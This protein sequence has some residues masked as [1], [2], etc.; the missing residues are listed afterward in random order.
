MLNI[1]KLQVLLWVSYLLLNLYDSCKQSNICAGQYW[2]SQSSIHF[3]I[4]LNDMFWWVQWT[5]YT[6]ES[7]L[8]LLH[9]VTRGTGNAICGRPHPGGGRGGKSYAEKADKGEG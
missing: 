9:F 1:L 4:G 7:I 8:K 2:K 5:V 3:F 6:T